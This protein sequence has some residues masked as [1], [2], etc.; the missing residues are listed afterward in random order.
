MLHLLCKS[1]RH[2]SA[3]SRISM[4]KVENKLLKMKYKKGEILNYDFICES[5]RIDEI[6]V[7]HNLNAKL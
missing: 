4:I 5:L 6:F 7:F 1:V 2:L 3:L